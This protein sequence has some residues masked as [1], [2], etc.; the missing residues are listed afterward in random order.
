MIAH[1]IVLS[2]NHSEFCSWFRYIQRQVCHVLMGLL[3]LEMI[4]QT[5]HATEE[6]RHKVSTEQVNKI[7][8]SANDDKRII[9]P[10]KIQTLAYGFRA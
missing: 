6:T 4:W 7:A 10:D 5:S 3:F 9:Q 2:E 1:L 8:L